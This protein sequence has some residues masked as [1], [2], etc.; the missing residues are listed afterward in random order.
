MLDLT[1]QLTHNGALYFPVLI[2]YTSFSFLLIYSGL[3]VGVL[4]WVFEGGDFS[5]WGLGSIYSVGPFVFC[6]VEALYIDMEE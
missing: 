4:D 5:W 2:L 6:G 1:L 3:G